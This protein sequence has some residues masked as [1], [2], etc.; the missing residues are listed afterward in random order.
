MKKSRLLLLP[1][2]ALTMLGLGCKPAAPRP[3]PAPVNV[4][5]KETSA[6]F[7]TVVN[8][9]VGSKAKF[10]DGLQVT[11]QA[12]DDSRCKPDVQCIWAGELSPLFLVT[13]GEAGSETTEVRLGTDRTRSAT[14]AAYTFA[15][16]DVTE[17]SAMV[18][19]SKKLAAN[20]DLIHI[21]LP[22]PN[23]LVKSPLGITGEARGTWFFEA[24]FPVKLLDANGKVIA[25]APA[26]AI[27][28]WMTQEFVPF[29]LS[30]PFPTPA[31]AT[32]TLVLEKDNPSGLPEHDASVSVP[33]RFAP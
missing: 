27:G 13:G 3:Q 8:F 20:A 28:D 21:T 32:G 17:T 26:Q 12:I 15:I 24:S 9:T 25:S 19:I 10:S 2:L 14:V 22:T 29:S 6:S 31:T 18:T 5:S 23:S 4:P 30:L 33:V 7:G 11:L 16:V 1:L